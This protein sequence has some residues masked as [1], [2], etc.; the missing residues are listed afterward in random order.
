MY[1]TLTQQ[2]HLTLNHVHLLLKKNTDLL[3]KGFHLNSLAPRAKVV[4]E[5]GGG[6][7][8]G[9]PLNRGNTE[10]TLPNLVSCVLTLN[11][12]NSSWQL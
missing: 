9:R 7:S 4:L 10:G 12:L 6:L 8:E 2:S 11:L 5:G 3:R 1:A